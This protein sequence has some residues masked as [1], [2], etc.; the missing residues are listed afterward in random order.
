MFR[1]DNL[2]EILRWAKTGLVITGKKVMRGKELVM[3][4]LYLKEYPK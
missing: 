2:S 1:R 4:G 3:K